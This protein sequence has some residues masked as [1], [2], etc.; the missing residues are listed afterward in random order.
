MLERLDQLAMTVPITLIYGTRS[1]MDNSTGE[2]VYAMRPEAYVDVHYVK[3]AG[4]HVHA[5]RPDVFNEIVNQ[6]CQLVDEGRDVNTRGR[7]K[8][9]VFHTH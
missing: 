3:G 4:H 5:D 7:S 8:G 1:W 9:G 6:A 2:K